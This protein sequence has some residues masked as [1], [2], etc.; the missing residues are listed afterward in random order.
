MTNTMWFHGPSPTSRLPPQRPPQLHFEANSCTL[1]FVSEIFVCVG[2]AVELYALALDYFIALPTTCV[3]LV[4]VSGSIG[5]AKRLI[6][7]IVT[8]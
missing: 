1:K 4:L 2:H 7:I 6:L 5:I 3:L 8:A